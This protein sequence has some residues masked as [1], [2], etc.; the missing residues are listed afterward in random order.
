[1]ELKVG[2]SWV[3]TER[4][5]RGN[6]KEKEAGSFYICVPLGPTCLWQYLYVGHSG[7]FCT[8]NVNW[9]GHLQGPQN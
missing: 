2:D 4:A 5:K 8:L 6:G 7:H 9:R 3:M 1:M